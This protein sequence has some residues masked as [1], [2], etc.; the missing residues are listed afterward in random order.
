MGTAVWLPPAPL[1]GRL[2]A[3]QPEVGQALPAAYALRARHRGV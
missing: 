1:W 2:Y 3:G